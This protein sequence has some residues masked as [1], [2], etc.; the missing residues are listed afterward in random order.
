[1]A[2]I[3][4]FERGGTRFRLCFPPHDL[5]IPVRF[6][7]GQVRAFGLPPA[8]AQAV[9]TGT[10][11]GSVE[12]GGSCNCPEVAFIAH[13]SGTHTEGLGHLDRQATPVSPPPFLLGATLVTVSPEASSKGSVISAAVL[14]PRLVALDPLFAEA[15]LVRTLP[16][17]PAKCQ[18]DWSAGEPPYLAPE[19]AV[20]LSRLADHL[21]ID[22]PSL[23]PQWDGGQLAAHRAFLADRPTRTITEL[24]FVDDAIPD[25]RYALSLQVAPLALDAAPSRP[26][27]FAVEEVA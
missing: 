2:A 7:T 5:A 24:V 20:M 21:L 12:Q 10:F 3:I 22:L 8:R 27:L 15:I 14:Q 16:N 1:M 9:R 6:V 17:D 19:A 25:G 13:A 18:R 11:V 23:D 26:L 4:V